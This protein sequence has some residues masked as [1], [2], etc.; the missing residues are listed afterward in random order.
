M[1]RITY[2]IPV[3]VALIISAPGTLLAQSDAAA[4]KLLQ[5]VSKKY[6][7]YKTIQADFTFAAQDQNQQKTA[8]TDKGTIQM[9]AA[10]GKYHIQMTDQVLISDG[11]SQWTV[12]KQEKEVQVTDADNSANSISPLNIFSFYQ[13]GYKYV[14]AADERVGNTSLHVVELSPEQ[15]RNS[16][17]FKIKLRI[18]KTTNLIHDV[19]VFDKSSTRYTYSIKNFV[20]NPTIPVAKFTFDKTQYAGMELVDLR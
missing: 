3:L 10:A 2:I 15:P 20:A 4:G 6:E 7:S 16:P 17:Y 11:K 8:Y 19:T 18:D 13:K 9:D 12:L 14:S 5:Q 1:K